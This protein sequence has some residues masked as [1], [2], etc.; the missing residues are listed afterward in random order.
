VVDDA[1]QN[2]RR[3]SSAGTRHSLRPEGDPTGPPATN[4]QRSE[5]AR[6]LGPAAFPGDATRLQAV[7]ADNDATDEVRRLLARLPNDRSFETVQEVIDH[8]GNQ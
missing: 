6:F 7:A 8:L 2:R 5:L 1:L 4:D 3:Q